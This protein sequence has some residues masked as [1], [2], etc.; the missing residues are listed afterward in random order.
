M[1][2]KGRGGSKDRDSKEDKWELAAIEPTD[3]FSLAYSNP[4]R[5]GCLKDIPGQYVASDPQGRVVMSMSVESQFCAFSLSPNSDYDPNDPKGVGFYQISVLEFDRES[6]SDNSNPIF[7]RSTP[8]ASPVVALALCALYTQDHTHNTHSTF[9][10]IQASSDS[11]GHVQKRLVY[12]EHDP[13]AVSMQVCLYVCVHVCV[14]VCLFVCLF[15][16]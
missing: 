15:V 6:E 9:V 16:W 1:N 14:H 5:P 8:N 11:S 13:T 4:N 7:D 3:S 2:T 10:S 12:Y